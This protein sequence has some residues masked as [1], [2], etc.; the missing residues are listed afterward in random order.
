[1]A[2]TSSA[3]VTCLFCAAKLENG[4][5]Y[6]RPGRESAIRDG[7]YLLPS[8]MLR[9]LAQLGGSLGEKASS[10]LTNKKYFGD[11]QLYWCESCR[12]GVAWPLFDESALSDY[13]R[14]FYWSS[15]EQHNAYFSKD[16]IL[17]REGHLDW[18]RT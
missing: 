4:K 11:K 17:P 18:T 8:W 10:V 3:P 12:T 6:L 9:A 1:M 7:A 14:D 13:Y 2:N 5:P 15:R 16:P